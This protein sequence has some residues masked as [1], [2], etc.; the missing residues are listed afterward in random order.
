MSDKISGVEYDWNTSLQTTYIG[1]D[2]GVLAQEIEEILPEAVVTRP[3]GYK[4]VKYE[5]LIPLLI[6]AIKELKAR[7]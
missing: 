4:A 2:V 6:Q 5:K 7:S 1:H 3:D